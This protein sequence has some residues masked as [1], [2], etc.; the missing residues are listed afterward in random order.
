M[1]N[2]ISMEA[3]DSTARIQVL[4]STLGQLRLN[5]IATLDAITTHLTRLI[6][7]TSADE[8]YVS[9]LAHSLAPCILRPRTENALTIEERHAYRL[10]RD[11]FD[12]KES[13]FGEL[14]RQSSVTA[15]AAGAAARQRAVSSTDESSRRAAMEA[16]QKAITE[17]QR[18]KSPAPAARHRRDKSSDGGRFPVVV[19]PRVEQNRASMSGPAKRMSLDVPGSPMTPRTRDL[20][21]QDEGEG[22][23]NGDSVSDS[24]NAAPSFAATAG[25][26][27]HIPPPMDDDSPIAGTPQSAGP[28]AATQEQDGINK[29]PSIKRSAAGSGARRLNRGGVGSVKERSGLRQASETL[30]ESGHSGV[31]LTDK[32]YDD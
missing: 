17:R 21:K 7:L 3:P 25:P 32:P 14:K 1:I 16:R 22:P 24:A 13:I 20:T 18:D 15:A 27:P 6:D 28:V 31:E 23:T 5:N 29:S 12:H 8:A 26:G 2:P 9:S 11:L 19:S 10:V 30:A 4:Q